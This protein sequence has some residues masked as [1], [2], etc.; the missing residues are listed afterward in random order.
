VVGTVGIG[1]ELKI[2]VDKLGIFGCG[3][4]FKGMFIKGSMV[5]AGGEK[6]SSLYIVQASYPLTKLL[7]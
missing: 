5:V 6:C 4:L 2:Y 3:V 7:Q 1:E